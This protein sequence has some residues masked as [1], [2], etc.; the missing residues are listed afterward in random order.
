MGKRNSFMVFIR[1]Q[2]SAFIG[3]VVDYSVMI[4]L[5][6]L[7]HVHYTLSIVC[8]GIT[9][10]IVN[11]LINRY[12]AFSSITPYKSRLDLQLLKF[13]SVAAGSIALKSTGTYFVTETFNLNYKISRLIVDALVAYAFNFV[14][15][16]Y[17]VFNKKTTC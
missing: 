14:L 6:E 11:F 7:G 1:S 3:V 2:I 12:W 10:A 8:G 13:T 16:K 9:G 17:W 15:M 4:L 5:T